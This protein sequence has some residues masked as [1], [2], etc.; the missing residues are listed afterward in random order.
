MLHEAMAIENE[1]FSSITSNLKC[2]VELFPEVQS[3]YDPMRIISTKFLRQ[4][5]KIYYV[6]FWYSLT[7]KVLNDFK[8]NNR[9]K[10]ALDLQRNDEWARILNVKLTMNNHGLKRLMKTFNSLHCIVLNRNRTHHTDSELM[11]WTS[12][13]FRALKFLENELVG[14]R[15]SNL[16]FDSIARW[17]RKNHDSTSMTKSGFVP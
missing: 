16:G 15:Q 11:C 2:T 14:G 1:D 4:A 13:F 17:T 9:K 8:F 12:L 3:M 10:F 5:P 7:R 6:R